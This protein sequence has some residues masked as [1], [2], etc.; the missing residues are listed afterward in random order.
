MT[1]PV[2]AVESTE[3]LARNSLGGCPW[4]KPHGNARSSH[5][6]WSPLTSWVQPW[7]PLFHRRNLRGF[8]RSFTI[9]ITTLIC[10]HVTRPIYEHWAYLTWW[11]QFHGFLMIFGSAYRTVLGTEV[12]KFMHLSASIKLKMCWFGSVPIS[13]SMAL[14]KN[15]KEKNT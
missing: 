9:I 2:V 5:S 8:L 15:L 4:W 10:E 6:C 11:F 13:L 12:Q 7:W 1:S 14:M 3:V